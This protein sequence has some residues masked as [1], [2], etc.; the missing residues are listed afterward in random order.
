M[1]EEPVDGGEVTSGNVAQLTFIKNGLLFGLNI[2][3][4]NYMDPTFR[5]KTYLGGLKWTN[6]LQLLGSK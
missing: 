1:M 3:L 2:F 5:P 6:G 4:V